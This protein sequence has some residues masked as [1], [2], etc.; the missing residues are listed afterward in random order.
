VRSDDPFIHEFRVEQNGANSVRW[1]S[2]RGQV[3]DRSEDGEPLVLAGLCLD[4]TEAR[5][6]QDA[7]DLLNRELSHRMKNL[8]SVVSSLVNMTSEH[9]PE[10]KAFVSSFQ[11]RLNTFS[12]AHELLMRGDWQPIP[13]TSLVE[14]ALS[15]VGVAGRV[16]LS[17]KGNIVLRSNDAQTVV[18]L[19]HELATNA[20]KYGALSNGSGRVD[21]SFES[22]C[23]ET[24]PLLVMRWGESGGPRVEAPGTRGFGV[25]LIERLTKRQRA[26]NTVLDWNPEG[27]QCCIEI[28]ISPPREQTSTG[29]PFVGS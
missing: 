11:T 14:K 10:A 4:V 26:G 21:L 19:L 6:T 7:Y 25:K 24:G 16:D 29:N 9:R 17:S 27:L 20:I 5:R 3:L 8:L 23:G 12:A 1:L 13:L 18:L 22:D 28:P 15:A 2:Y